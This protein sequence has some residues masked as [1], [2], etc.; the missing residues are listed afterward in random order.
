MS[1]HDLFSILN[2]IAVVTWLLLAIFPRRRW[3]AAVLAGWAVPAFFALVY[4]TIVATTFPGIEGGFSS[5]T[6]VS[7]LFANPWALLAGW[8]HYLAFDLLVG[9]WEMRDAVEK[10]IPHWRVVPCLALTFL[11]GPAGWLAYVI[12]RRLP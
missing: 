11:F 10:R 2:I 3:V 12:V 9:A 5:L 7:T 4:V 8:T 1:P 6:A